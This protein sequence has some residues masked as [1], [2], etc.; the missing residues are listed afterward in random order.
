MK[1]KFE[2]TIEADNFQDAL[3]WLEDCFSDAPVM[4]YGIV[5]KNKSSKEIK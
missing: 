4:A 1:F 3:D 2:G 5:G